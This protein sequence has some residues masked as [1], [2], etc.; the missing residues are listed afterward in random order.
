[1][2]TLSGLILSVAISVLLIGQVSAQNVTSA[3]TDDQTA[4]QTNS[5]T[6]NCGKFVDNNKDG[7]CDIKETRCV[8]NKGANFVDN[9]K[10]GICDNHADGNTCKGNGNCCKQNSQK[11]Q[12]CSK[13]TGAQHRQGCGNQCPGHTTPNKK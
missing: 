2:K 4:K 8:N 7:V 3:S 6:Q 12:N 13:G 5:T 9:N 1:M 11:N 10:D